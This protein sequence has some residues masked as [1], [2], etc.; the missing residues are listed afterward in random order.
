MLRGGLLAILV[1]GL[2]GVLAELVLLEHTG[3]AWQRLPLFLIAAARVILGWHALDRSRLAV[4]FLQGTMALFILTGGI[5]VVLHFKGNLEFEREMQP[6]AS[7]IPLLWETLKGAT[8]TLAPGTMVLLGLLGLAY[9]YR[10]PA[11]GRRPG[12]ADGE[13]M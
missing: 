4:R 9:T 8:P 10:H 7:G 5:G 1:T 13:P 2:A 6:S 12:G 3:E 11:L